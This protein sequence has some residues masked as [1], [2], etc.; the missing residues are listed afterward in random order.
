MFG[1]NKSILLTELALE[2]LPCKVEDHG[3]HDGVRE[4]HR[5]RR[6]TRRQA[7]EHT[8]EEK[9]EERRNKSKLNEHFCFKRRKILGVCSKEIVEYVF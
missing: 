3:E 4:V 5:Q 8:R 7:D 6:A 2:G 9:V 1:F